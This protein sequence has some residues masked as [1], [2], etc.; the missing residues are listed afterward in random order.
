MLTNAT[1]PLS[2]RQQ[3]DVESAVQT[4]GFQIVPADLRTGDQLD[5]AFQVF[6][7]EKVQVVDV[8]QDTLFFSYRRQIA[9]LAI[10]AKLPTIFGFRDHV[11]AG[12]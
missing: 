3:H 10:S 9:L 2:S 1:S 6:V 4:S 5:A 11:E 12:G 8:L 7:R